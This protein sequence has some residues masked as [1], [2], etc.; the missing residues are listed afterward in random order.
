[1]IISLELILNDSNKIIE[2][3]WSYCLG[4]FRENNCF[5]MKIFGTLNAIWYEVGEDKYVRQRR[6]RFANGTWYVIYNFLVGFLG[7]LLEL[8]CL[9]ADCFF[10]SSWNVNCL[11]V[12]F[13]AF[14]S[15]SLFLNLL[16]ANMFICALSL[17]ISVASSPDLLASFCEKLDFVFERKEW[18]K[19]LNLLFK[20]PYCS[21]TFLLNFM[22]LL[23]IIDK[24]GRLKDKLFKLSLLT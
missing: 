13:S 19:S 22:P 20:F 16:L 21:E 23:F 4:W 18:G 1:M 7:T 12:W 6:L 17:F 2:F 24:F 14:T 8:E 15:L 3:S 10:S 9:F 11:S 5:Y